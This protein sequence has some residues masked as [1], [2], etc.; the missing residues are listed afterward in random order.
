MLWDSADRTTQVEGMELI[1]ELIFTAIKIN[2]TINFTSKHHVYE[3]QN[4]AKQLKQSI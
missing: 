1:L 2:K 4:Q 3:Y